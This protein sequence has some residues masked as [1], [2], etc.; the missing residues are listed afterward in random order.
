MRLEC[1]LHAHW[2][3][4]L[5]AELEMAHSVGAGFESSCAEAL[6]NTP[7]RIRA[8]LTAFTA[9]SRSLGAGR[10]RRSHGNGMRFEESSRSFTLNIANASR[11]ACQARTKAAASGRNFWG[12]QT[13][14]WAKLVLVADH[15]HG[16]I[17]VERQGVIEGVH[18]V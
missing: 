4:V 7:V 2:E 10:E 3:D 15:G 1:E 8:R 14:D 17:Q 5:R 16:S 11:S 9:F 12:S 6:S 13:I 18:D